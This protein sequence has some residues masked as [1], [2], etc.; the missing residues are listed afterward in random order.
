VEVILKF[1]YTP[2]AICGQESSTGSGLFRCTSVFLAYHQP[3]NTPFFCIT[4]LIIREWYKRYTSGQSVKELSFS[5]SLHLKIITKKYSTML[6]IKT[7][8]IMSYGI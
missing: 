8:K 2:Y 6:G 7:V 5:S 3:I 4:I 1:L